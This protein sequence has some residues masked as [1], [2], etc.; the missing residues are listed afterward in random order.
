MDRI[1]VETS[2]HVRLNYIPATLVHR[3]LGWGVDAALYMI[4]IFV[5]LWI[6]GGILPTQISE[7]VNLGWVATLMLSLPYFI[8]Y[9]LVETVWGGRTIGK[10]VMGIRVTKLDGTRAGPGD[11]IIRWLF[12]FIE[13]SGTGGVVAILTILINGKGQR[14]GDLVAKTC[15]IMEKHDAISHQ[16]LFKNTQSDRNIVFQ[17]AAEL[18]DKDIQVIQTLLNSQKDYSPR[19]RRK[20]MD[21]SRSLIEQKTGAKD[22]S[23][24]SEEYL[25]TIIRDY[26]TIYGARMGES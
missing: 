2:R 23:L 10:K 12:R 20:L 8:Y 9:P 24:S 13:I 21:R 19:A 3:M 4:Y 18:E 7:N 5:F 17:S 15:V 25:K 6:W 11:Y 16:E 26:N 14:L 1:D 22:S